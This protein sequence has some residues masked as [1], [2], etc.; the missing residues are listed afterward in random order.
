MAQRTKF[1]T[2]EEYFAS[3]PPES[4]ATLE[5][6]KRIVEAEVRGA[7]PTIAYQMPAFRKGRV[8]VYFAAF[9]HHVGIY[10][11]AHGD[12]ALEAALL[13]YRG[14]KGNLKFPYNRPIPFDLIR[15]VV[16]ALAQQYSSGPV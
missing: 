8:F 13:P 5:E 7:E 11:P 12:A 1:A 6:I 9:K 2:M 4:R 15:R 14:E 3:V 16:R 10:P